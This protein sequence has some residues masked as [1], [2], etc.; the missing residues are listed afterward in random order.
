MPFYLRK[1]QQWPE[2]PAQRGPAWT[3]ERGFRLPH[4]PIP[5][6]MPALADI[7]VRGARQMH[8]LDLDYS[9]ES[10]SWVD[11]LLNSFGKEGSHEMAEMVLCAGAYVGETLVRNHAFEWVVFPNDIARE[12]R[13]ST[14]VQSG[15]VRGNPL[16]TAFDV[17]DHGYPDYSALTVA[18]HLIAEAQARGE[19]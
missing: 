2:P 3:P 7:T 4:P 6:N 19:A 18:R 8:K 15:E 17:V 9:V 16:G 13:F 11:Q 10:V 5:E 14:G 12:M 1:D